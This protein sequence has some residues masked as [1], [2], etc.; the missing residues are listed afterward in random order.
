[1]KK[2]I[3]FFLL[4]VPLFTDYAHG[5]D[6][7]GPQPLPPYG[8]FSTFSA[9]SLKQGKAGMALGFEKSERPGF[10][11][12]TGQFGYGILDS[13]ELDVSIPY[14][15]GG[16]DYPINGFEDT[17]LAL[18]YRFFDEGKYGPSVAVVATGSLPTGKDEISTEGSIGGGLAVSKK[19]GPFY[20]HANLFYS[21]PFTE[22]FKDD[23]TF[24][25]GIDFS[26]SH[27]FRILGELYG[28]KSYSGRLDRLEA[29]FGYRLFTSDDILTT[30]GVGFDLKN[31][32]PVYRILLSL[33]YLF[34]VEKQKIKK[35]YDVVD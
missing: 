3:F 29:R 24:A 4:A 16:N 31:R 25:A 21:K 30:I 35:V 18:R 17:S 6:L 28:K 11:R 23:L 9:D 27:S 26:A 33:T 32:S 8:V 22:R 10:Y 1:M 12:Y 13:L 20:G 2:Y 5:L 15:D 19:V 34:N 14:Y 7:K